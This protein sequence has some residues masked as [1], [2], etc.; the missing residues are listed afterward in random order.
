MAGIMELPHRD[1]FSNN[2]VPKFP[3]FLEFFKFKKK[4]VFKKV[5][6]EF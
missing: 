3:I 1:S 2:G 6:K 5:L 4:K